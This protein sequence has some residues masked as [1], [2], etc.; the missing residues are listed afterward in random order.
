M[1]PTAMEEISRVR[2]AATWMRRTS[3]PIS[4]YPKVGKLSTRERSDAEHFATGR[5]PWPCRW[6][7]T[8]F[9]LARGE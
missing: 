4:Q 6:T 3:K 1:E 8:F 2:T 5:Y 9:D 7:R